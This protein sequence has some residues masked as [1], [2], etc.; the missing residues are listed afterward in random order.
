MYSGL[1]HPLATN[2]GGQNKL[3][4]HSYSGLRCRHNANPQSINQSIN[5][6]IIHTLS[7]SLSITHSCVFLP[8][9]SSETPWDTLKLDVEPLNVR[10]RPGTPRL[11]PEPDMDPERDPDPEETDDVKDPAVGDPGVSEPDV[12]L[13]AALDFRL[14]CS[15][16]FSMA[17]D[18]GNDVFRKHNV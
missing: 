12:L 4:N 15:V 16:N 3:N 18:F 8:S 1:Q 13:E 2:E 6:P 7:L 14:F 11:D 17:A 10:L 9:L 5:Q